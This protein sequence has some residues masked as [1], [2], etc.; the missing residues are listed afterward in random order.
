MTKEVICVKRSTTL[1]GIVATFRKCN[2]HTLPVVEDGRLVGTITFED[3]L[4]VFQPYGVEVSE[5]L[6]TIPF[7]READEETDILMTDI[8]SDLG[9]LVVADD[10]MN[11]GFVTIEEDADIAY[12]RQVMKLHNQTRLLVVLGSRLE[13]IIS[14]FDIVLAIFKEKGIVKEA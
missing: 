3:L 10:I 5:M 11:T 9:L 1:G 7:V 14:L 8:E 4:K 2:F 12:A 6:K 13:G